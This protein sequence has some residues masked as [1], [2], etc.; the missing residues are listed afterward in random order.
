[1]RTA[2]LLLTPCTAVTPDKSVIVPMVIS[3][4]VTPRTGSA[5]RAAIVPRTR[6]PATMGSH[7][8]IG[9]RRIFYPFQACFYDLVTLAGSVVAIKPQGG[10]PGR[11]PGPAKEQ[12]SLE[13]I[14]CFT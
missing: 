10:S 8:L 1:M 11:C 7:P 12:R 13:P 9:L 4:S 14:H 5:A 3:V 6:L 2:S